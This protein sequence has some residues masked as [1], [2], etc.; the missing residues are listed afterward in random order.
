MT[1]PEAVHAVAGALRRALD[2]RQLG[3]VGVHVRHHVRQAARSPD[4]QDK[5]V[6]GL[7]QEERW[8]LDAVRVIID[9]DV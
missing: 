2:H 3:G 9:K 8:A 6:A 1:L 7:D 4:G 5:G